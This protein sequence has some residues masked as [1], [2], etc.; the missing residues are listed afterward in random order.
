VHLFYMF[1]TAIPQL[2]GSTST[3]G[4]SQL[5]KEMLLRNLIS[6][7]LQFIV[8]CAIPYRAKLP[9]RRAADYFYH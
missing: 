5:L 1:A 6:A 7:I 9:R 4:Y 2:E 8:G 3:T